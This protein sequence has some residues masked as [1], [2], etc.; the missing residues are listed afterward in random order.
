MYKFHVKDNFENV[1]PSSPHFWFYRELY[2]SRSLVGN[3]M[4]VGWVNTQGERERG[5]QPNPSIMVMT[6]VLQ[7]TQ[8]DILKKETIHSTYL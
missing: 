7:L 3:V 1:L 4:V 8:W 2:Y 6:W 5:V